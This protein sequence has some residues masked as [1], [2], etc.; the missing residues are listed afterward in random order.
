MDLTHLD[1]SGR[2]KVTDSGFAGLKSL[3]FLIISRGKLSGSCL[4]SLECLQTLHYQ[5]CNAFELIFAP[6]LSRLIEVDLSR[7]PNVSN[8]MLR[9]LR[10]AKIVH[11][12]RCPGISGQGIEH[13][14]SVEQLF[15]DGCSQ[16]TDNSLSG[17]PSC[18]RVLSLSGC[19]KMSAKCFFVLEMVQMLDLRKCTLLLP[20]D[21]RTIR[22]A[23]P[24]RLIR[25]DFDHSFSF[26]R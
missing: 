7:S 18:L 20:S 8:E 2:R 25:T 17:I 5:R 4:G 15:L 14:R 12:K 21:I 24:L 9:H 6:G 11:L 22:Q 10:G 19:V 13:L 3:K 23:H 16:L 1:L 26:R